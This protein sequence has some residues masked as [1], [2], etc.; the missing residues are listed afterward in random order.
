MRVSK[1]NITAKY[2]SPHRKNSSPLKAKH[3]PSL[4]LLPA[5]HYDHMAEPDKNIE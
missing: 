2:S 4:T 3:L 5:L 1:R